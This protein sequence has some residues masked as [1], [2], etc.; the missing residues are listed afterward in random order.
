MSK[1]ANIDEGFFPERAAGGFTRIDGT[2]Q[3]YT[4]NALIESE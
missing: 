4:V 3:F 1:P 2:V